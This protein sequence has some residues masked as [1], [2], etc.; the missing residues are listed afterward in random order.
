MFTRGL[1]LL[2]PLLL[3]VGNADE[4]NGQKKESGCMYGHPGI[5]G[6]P[7]HNGLPGRDGRD[8]VKG[9]KGERGENSTTI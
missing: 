5:P 7:G 8:G 1:I 4:L 2:V 6:D 3:V 9:D